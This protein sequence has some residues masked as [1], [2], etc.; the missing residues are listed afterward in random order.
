MGWLLAQ[1]YDRQMRQ[2]ERA[3]LGAWRAEVL[4]HASGEVLEIGAGTGANID[5]YG[6]LERLVLTEPDRHMR[7]KLVARA[8]ASSAP[9]TVSA[10][11]AESL[12]VADA[13]FDTVVTTLV[14]C[15]VNDLDGAL[16]EI[17]RVLRPGGK[18]IFL[19]HV[20]AVAGSSRR[21]WQG[22]MEPLWKR[23]FG[24]CH[25]TR[26]P[27]EAIE[28]AGFSIATIERA[29]LRKAMPLVRPSVR[30]LATR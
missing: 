4:A 12:G 18:L 6:D 8:D 3:C 1:M 7:A 14:L 24:N 17:R 26:D 9:I 30:G 2:I 10:D 22:R 20:G 15:S 29:S 27:A 28:R 23:L 25:L 19:E 5:S 11:H 21:K 13:S 16:A